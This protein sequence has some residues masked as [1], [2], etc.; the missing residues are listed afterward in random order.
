MTFTIPDND[1]TSTPNPQSIWMQAD[2]DT[3]TAAF[4]GTHIISGCEITAQGTP[5]MTVHAAAGSASVGSVEASRSSGDLTIGASDVTPRI[6]LIVSD[7]TGVYSVIAGVA[8]A[9]P[10]APDAGGL[11]LH[12]MVLVRAN[13][14]EILSTDIVD[15]RILVDL[16]MNR[17]SNALS[18][19]T[20][21]RISADTALGTRIDT[22]SQ[23]I[24]TLSQQISVLSQAVST[25]SQALST[26][27]SNRVTADA[28]LSTRIDTQSQSISVVSQS[29]S[30]E[31][32]DRLSADVALSVRI[33]TQSQKISVLSQG[34]SVVS[35]TLSVETADRISA[36]AALSIR[37]DTLSIPGGTA[38]VTSNEL[39]IETADRMSADTELSIR[40]DTQSQSISVLSQ[41]ISVLSQSISVVSQ[42][43]SVEIADRISAVNIVSDALSVEIADRF[44][45]DTSLEGFIDILSGKISVLSQQVSALSQFV[46]TIFD[47][48][49]SHTS[50]IQDL[51]SADTALSVRIDTQSNKISTLS[52]Q[53][54]TLSQS[55][56]SQAAALSVRIDTQSQSISVLS[57][58]VSV[59]SQQ[60]SVLSAM[61]VVTSGGTSG[62]IPQWTGTHRLIDSA[63]QQ[64]SAGIQ[65][66]GNIAVVS[67]D[68]DI[69]YLNQHPVDRQVVTLSANQ[70]LIHGFI[71]VGTK[72]YGSTR[73]GGFFLRFNDLEDLTDYST[74]TSAGDWEDI[75]Y[76]A[77]KGN[78][79]VIDGSGGTTIHVNEVVPSTLSVNA[80]IADSR[81]GDPGGVLGLT[82][83]SIT[84]DG[85]Y[86]YVSGRRLKSDVTFHAVIYQ[87]LLS[88]FSYVAQ[89]EITGMSTSIPT[90]HC[91]RY[92]GHKLYCTGSDNPA[93]IARITPG[94]MALEQFQE[95]GSQPTVFT[96]DMGITAR[97]VFALSES[98]F[99]SKKLVRF[100][101]SDLSQ[102]E[103]IDI[104]HSSASGVACHYDGEYIWVG[105]ITGSSIMR[106]SPESL[107]VAQF[108][109]S[110]LDG[111]NE[112]TSD[113][114]RLFGTTWT[115]DPAKVF[116]VSKPIGVPGTSGGRMNAVSGNIV[117]FGG[118]YNQS[119]SE[120]IDILEDSGI[121]PNTLSVLSQAISV[122]SQQVST[123][124]QT[125]SVGDAALSVRINTQSQ[126]I[127][128][129][130]QQI[131]VLSQV[132]SAGD[133]AL[134]ARI[135]TQSDKISVLSQQLSVQSNAISVLSQQASVMSNAL[136][137]VASALSQA[138]SLF[139]NSISVLSQ[140][141]SA[142]S[143]QVSVLSN[144]V[145]VLSAAGYL[146]AV[147][148]GNDQTIATSTFVNVS[149][150]SLTVLAAGIY[151][152]E[153]Q[154][155]HSFSTTS[156][157]PGY[158]YTLTY[159]GMAQMA[160]KMEMGVLL[161][162]ITGGV[163][164]QARY[165][166]FNETTPGSGVA[167]TSATATATLSGTNY[168]TFIEAA[169]VV[170]NATGVLQ[171][172]AKGGIS[173][174][175]QSLFVRRG[176]YI[177]LYKIG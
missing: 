81:S 11:A 117:A 53:V 98:E 77:S 155:I 41:K 172:Q 161:G 73:S 59:I 32:I 130:S 176:S 70:H 114:Q 104:G 78:I 108:M 91:L 28:A 112:I 9:N 147:V 101:K 69:T 25:V 2:I 129:L 43:L 37:I 92:D 174:A 49:F 90:P 134:S 160:G 165:A 45:A 106:V 171:V 137:N 110:G 8:N 71:R 7:N 27:I 68:G 89:F 154:L 4:A 39:S 164:A 36:D 44:V 52:Q 139:S 175:Q 83:H 31:T 74:T 65:V 58:A 126:S 29:I 3:I 105:F 167:I 133:A 62:Y 123:L 148:S 113:Q 157:G 26:E 15:K 95:M 82:M 119:R 102:F 136:S 156:A 97:Y 23:S 109:V 127:S 120:N 57:Q 141:V 170:S 40:I 107:E 56:S 55:I 72:L 135:D 84:S 125:V 162:M 150:L 54:S 149:G 46:S 60:I 61:A 14:T 47:V 42:A 64:V 63:I 121:A 38:S 21:N 124:S 115:D 13:T 88:D 76:I 1:E 16:G 48:T 152:L 153:G 163:S 12:A 50:A 146:Q 111:V 159:P 6:D 131:S 24:S 30:V 34:I 132:V 10:K 19:E 99:A 94:T 67:P 138:I 168:P 166:Y 33:D 66:S 128:V 96:D 75:I 93:W 145:S 85:T 5:D 51:I 100:L 18:V 143:Q 144:A 151:K 87:Y 122:L 79:Y 86:L 22:Q 80:V 35:Q 20:V 116:R 118:L 17:V 140:S 142:L 169:F 177:R 103:L 173:A 158:G